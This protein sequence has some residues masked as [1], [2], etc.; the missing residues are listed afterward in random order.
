MILIKQHF[1]FPCIFLLP[2]IVG[3]TQW[4]NGLAYCKLAFC[5]PGKGIRHALVLMGCL[6]ATRGVAGPG[7]HWP[8]RYTYAQRY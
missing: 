3:I 2:L 7:L 8:A 4:L 6:A 1:S 5:Q